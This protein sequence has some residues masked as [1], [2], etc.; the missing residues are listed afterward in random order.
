MLKVSSDDQNQ[1]EL[2]SGYTGKVIPEHNNLMM[3]YF[4]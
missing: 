3:L 1:V 4:L 2:E